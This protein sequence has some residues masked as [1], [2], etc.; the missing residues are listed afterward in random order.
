M[1]NYKQQLAFIIPI[2]N[3]I[4][5]IVT[6]IR[7]PEPPPQYICKQAIDQYNNVYNFVICNPE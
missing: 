4:V 1:N 5:L 7:L 3:F 2:L 6:F